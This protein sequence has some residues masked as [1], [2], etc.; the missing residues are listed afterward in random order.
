M[1]RG[2]RGRALLA[3]L[4]AAGVVAALPASAGGTTSAQVP[5]RRDV[6]VTVIR[7]TTADAVV[8]VNVDIGMAVRDGTR[9]ASTLPG[10]CKGPVYHPC[11][12]LDDAVYPG[13]QLYTLFR[14]VE[15]DSRHDLRAGIRVFNASRARDGSLVRHDWARK[16]TQADLELYSVEPEYG[17]VRLRVPAFPHVRGRIGYS[18]RIGH[19]EMPRAGEPDVGRL[20]GRATGTDGRPM[21]PRSFKLDVFGH[22]NTG[23]RIEGGLTV[24]G[25]GGAAVLPGTT[26]GAFRTKPLW[27]GAYDVHVQ[28][29]GA[30]FRCGLDVV[31]GRQARF[32]IDFRQADLGNPRCRPMRTLA[33]GVPG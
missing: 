8:Q 2:R 26:D 32:D 9:C 16:V 6:D 4:L 20:V 21:P 1:T 25:F 3:G 14:V 27:A 19:I 10:V 29:K 23:H 11:F 24:Y 7:T 17:D 33:Q 5:D 30:G 12:N 18:D 13:C 31:G 28:R 22:G 15:P